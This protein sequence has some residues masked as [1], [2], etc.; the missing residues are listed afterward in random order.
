M[1]LLVRLRCVIN[2]ISLGWLAGANP[3]NSG[4]LLAYIVGLL[5]D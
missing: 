5:F 3:L 4:L 2:P 1:L